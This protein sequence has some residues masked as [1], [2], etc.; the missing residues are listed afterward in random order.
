M[1]E[2]RRVETG[3]SLRAAVVAAK[4][5]DVAGFV[6]GDDDFG[7]RKASKQRVLLVEGVGH[8]VEHQRGGWR[9]AVEGGD[10]VRGEH[11]TVGVDEQELKTHLAKKVLPVAPSTAAVWEAVACKRDCVEGKGP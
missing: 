6:V 7:G 4:R 10:S 9:D 2:G 8:G 3:P 1:G 11:D 5:P